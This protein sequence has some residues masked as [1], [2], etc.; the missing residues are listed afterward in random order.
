MCP[1]ATS[2]PSPSKARRP[3]GESRPLRHLR[4]PEADQEHARLDLQ[5]VRA[6]EDRQGLPQVPAP[7]GTR[8]PRL[9]QRFDSM[10][11]C[12]S[13]AILALGGLFETSP[14]NWP[15]TPSS[16]SDEATARAL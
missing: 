7:P 14:M 4:S 2:P 12:P 6:L 8:M 3:S 16:L 11:V 15:R 1:R 10:T 5:H 13:A 9:R